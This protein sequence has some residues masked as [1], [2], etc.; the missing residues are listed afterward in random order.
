[1]DNRSKYEMYLDYHNIPYELGIDLM[2]SNHSGVDFWDV[3]KLGAIPNMRDV[4][5][6]VKNTTALQKLRDRRNGF[7]AECDWT[8]GKDIPD[9]VSIPWATYRQA[10]RDMPA[11]TQDPTRPVWPTKPEGT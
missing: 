7:L 8:Q 2:A 6:A 1:M 9:S 11:N 3:E 10:L 4:E 5:L